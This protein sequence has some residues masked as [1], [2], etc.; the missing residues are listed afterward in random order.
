MPSREILELYY[1]MGGEIITIGSDAH[2][3]K[4]ICDHIPEMQNLLKEIGFK[5]IY[6]FDQMKPIFHSFS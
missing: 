3:E 1:K 2:N 6:T 4:R 5:G